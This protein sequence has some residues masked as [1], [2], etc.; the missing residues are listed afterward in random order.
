MSGGFCQV[1]APGVHSVTPDEIAP[2]TFIGVVTKIVFHSRRQ[3]GYILRVVEDWYPNA[4]FMSADAI[5]SFEHLKAGDA[6]ATDGCEV[7]GE[8]RSP[9]AMG[10]QDG[11]GPVSGSQ[12]M[13]E[14]FRAAFGLAVQRGFSML[15]DDDKVMRAEVPF[16]FAASG[17]QKPQWITTDDHAVVTRCPQRPTPGP[18]LMTHV[19][20]SLDGVVIRCEMIHG[21]AIECDKETKIGPAGFEP[22]TKGLCVP[23]QLPLPLSSL[24]SGPYLRRTILRCMR[25]PSGLYTFPLFAGLARD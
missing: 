6:N 11:V 16:V 21:E 18:K 9:N 4:G 5:E 7:L 14:G 2:A 10:V 17:D 8:Q 15:V 19:A 13:E 12:A 1:L 25:L 23:L 3:A 20:Q 24:W 22:A